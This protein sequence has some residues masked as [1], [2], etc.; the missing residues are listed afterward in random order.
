MTLSCKKNKGPH[1]HTTHGHV[2]S[3]LVTRR[4]SKR[5]M[6]SNVQHRRVRERAAM[7][8]RG[9]GGLFPTLVLWSVATLLEL[10]TVPVVGQPTHV[11]STT[12][13]ATS[14]HTDV[15]A[16]SATRP[17]ATNDTTS[18]T[19]T[20]TTTTASSTTL[21]TTVLAGCGGVGRCVTL[22]DCA[23]CLDAINSTA[24]FPHTQAQFYSMGAAAI[25]RY[26]TT[27]ASSKR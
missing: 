10:T 26:V 19:T 21:T 25:R 16:A 15:V 18:I 3:E 7:R 14:T 9:H 20:F 5:S 6:S 23:Q 1:H 27:L 4:Q 22:V 17:I 2:I 13:P 24:A 11:S 12:T 8:R